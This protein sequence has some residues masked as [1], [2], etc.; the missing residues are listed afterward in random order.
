[1]EVDNAEKEKGKAETKEAKGRLLNAESIFRK[2]Q[3]QT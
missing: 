2:S 3:A 1:M